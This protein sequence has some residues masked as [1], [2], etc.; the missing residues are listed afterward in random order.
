MR[1]FLLGNTIYFN[2]RFEKSVWS[3]KY[4]IQ[5]YE[6]QNAMQLNIL[7]SVSILNDVNQ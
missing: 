5:I 1:Y 7:Q 3:C 4:I 6:I 2:Q